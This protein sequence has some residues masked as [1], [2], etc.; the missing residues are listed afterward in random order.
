MSAHVGW[1]FWVSTLFAE[2]TE[3]GMLAYDEKDYCQTPGRGRR[4][5]ATR[6]TAAWYHRVRTDPGS[7]RTS[8]RRAGSPAPGSRR[9]AQRTR[10]HLGTNRGNPRRRGGQVAVLVDAGP[11]YAYVDADDRHHHE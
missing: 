1:A 9:R 10:R 2:G 7:R 3:Q 8:S 11:L 4:Q 6:S 5:A